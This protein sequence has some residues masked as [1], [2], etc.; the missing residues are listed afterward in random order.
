M[1]VSVASSIVPSTS[2]SFAV[3][4]IV[5]AVVAS[6]A[7]VPLSFTAT[8]ASFTSLTVIVTV[9]VLLVAPIHSVT[10]P[11]TWNVSD[12]ELVSSRPAL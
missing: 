9:A 2:V 6:S 12:A 8:G 5:S 4:S 3:K 10:P 7:T 11:C 1:I